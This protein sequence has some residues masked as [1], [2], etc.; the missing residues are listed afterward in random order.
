MALV[1]PQGGSMAMDGRLRELLTMH[2]EWTHEQLLRC[3]RRVFVSVNVRTHL[4]F[5]AVPHLCMAKY[6]PL[7]AKQKV[8]T[9]C[10]P[11]ARVLA[12]HVLTEQDR[13][14]QHDRR[15]R[16][17]V[18]VNVPGQL[19]RDRARRVRCR[20]QGADWPRAVGVP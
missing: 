5:Q 7:C 1:T 2:R 13:H 6:N 14:Q 11:L 10:R 19:E 3:S 4:R 17:E 8:L 12:Y 16:K 18:R 9:R 20:R 15:S